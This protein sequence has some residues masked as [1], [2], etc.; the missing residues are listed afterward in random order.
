MTL[1]PQPLDLLETV[2]TA[3]RHDGGGP[4]CELGDRLVRLA[5]AADT[6]VV[7]QAEADGS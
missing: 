7:A 4:L 1:R 2:I 3:E 6:R 5:S